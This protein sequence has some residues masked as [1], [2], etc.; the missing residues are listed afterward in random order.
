MKAHA[1]EYV[2]TI[3]Q[4]THCADCMWLKNKITDVYH[5]SGI[6]RGEDSKRWHMNIIS[7]HWE[8]ERRKQDFPAGFA[9]VDVPAMK[10]EA[11]DR[12][13]FATQDI[14]LISELLAQIKYMLMD[15]QPNVEIETGLLETIQ[16]WQ[17][18]SQGHYLEVLACAN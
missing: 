3:V 12:L 17:A 9:T 18:P 5:F 8:R 6:V 2:L 14:R 16:N 13:V 4:H 15:G 1:P 10:L 7:P 11:D